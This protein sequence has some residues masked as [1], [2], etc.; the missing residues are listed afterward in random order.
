MRQPAPRDRF[1]Q[2]PRTTRETTE[3]LVTLPILYYDVSCVVALFEADLEG[4]RALLEGTGLAAGARVGPRAI[5]AM[6]F[7][8]YRHT[9]V[10]AYREVGTAILAVRRGEPPPVF[11]LAHMLAPLPRRRMGA[12]VVDLP[13]TTAAANA[14]GR[15]LWGYPKFITDITFRLHDRLFDC[16]VLD[17]DTPTSRI[18]QMEGRMGPG[19]PAP[20]M[21]LMTY[22]QLDG[23]MMRTHVDV[24]GRVS[25]RSA[26]DLTLRVGPSEHRMAQNLRRLGLD[27]AHPKLVTTTDR[28]QS[29]LH[30]GTP[31]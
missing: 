21:S 14:A 17:P 1:F 16:A 25:A 4:V 12:Y 9:T 19:V 13:V 3:G 20:P 18:C 31:A 29:K 26:G 11:P 30:A 6:A 7:Y 28:F 22:S 10:G 2:E 24:R 27:G 8:D 15:E 23:A 5:V